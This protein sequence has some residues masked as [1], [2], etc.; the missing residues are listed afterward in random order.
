MWNNKEKEKKIRVIVGGRRR[1][2]N[3][4]GD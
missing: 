1:K 4:K 3:E 2:Q